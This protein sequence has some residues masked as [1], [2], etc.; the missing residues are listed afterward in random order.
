MKTEPGL[1]PPSGTTSTGRMSSNRTT[2]TRSSYA[3][4]TSSATS[5]AGEGP[6]APRPACLWPAHCPGGRRSGNV[7]CG[8]SHDHM[9]GQ[10]LPRSCPG[11]ARWPWV[12]APFRVCAPVPAVVSPLGV[13][14]PHPV[15]SGSH[16]LSGG[17]LGSTPF[18]QVL[19]GPSLSVDS[20]GRAVCCSGHLR[21][22][23]LGL[24]C[25]VQDRA[26]SHPWTDWPKQGPG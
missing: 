24:L 2:V 22:S 20:Q 18:T 3:T 25:C 26:C 16:R 1:R 10:Q 17:R 11:G 7:S 19:W 14:C 5:C 23:C 15:S 6:L 21:A 13:M 9:F 12:K 8:V 4:P